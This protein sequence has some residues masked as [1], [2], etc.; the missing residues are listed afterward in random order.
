MYWV[1]FMHKP[2]NDY[3]YI[4]IGYIHPIQALNTYIYIYIYIWAI[5]IYVF[6]FHLGISIYYF[7]CIH[8]F[9]Y[10]ERCYPTSL[11]PP[12]KRVALNSMKIKKA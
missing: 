5:Y 10:V 1:C 9:R 6:F 12:M 11:L 4:Y 7:S 3:I 8:H 2:L